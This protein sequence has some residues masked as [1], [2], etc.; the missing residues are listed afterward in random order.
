MLPVVAAVVAKSASEK[1]G[2]QVGDR[3]KQVGDQPITAW[4]QFVELV[5][6]APGEPCKWWLSAT[7]VIST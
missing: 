6:Q 4:A 5:Q 2:L 3:I 1:A 7:T